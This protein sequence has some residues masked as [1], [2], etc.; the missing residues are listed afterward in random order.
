MADLSQ[1][2]TE[3]L[4]AMLASQTAPPAAPPAGNQPPQS[5]VATT[6]PAPNP[7]VVP[8]ITAPTMDL[9]KIPTD[10]L[11]RMLDKQ[12]SAAPTTLPSKLA[13][14]TTSMVK[15]ALEGI[16]QTVAAPVNLASSAIQEGLQLAAKAGLVPD[17]MAQGFKSG[18]A[19]VRQ[20]M[21][22]AGNAVENFIVPSDTVGSAAQQE[23]PQISKY[24]N[25]V[26]NMVGSA[27]TAGGMVGKLL[28][29]ASPVLSGAATQGAQG[30]LMGA[31]ANPE[32]PWKG[33]TIGAGIGGAGGAISGYA[34]RASQIINDKIDDAERIG[35]PAM[36]EAGLK[37]IKGAFDSGGKDLTTEESSQSTNIA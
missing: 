22:T 4:Q 16:G 29:A 36:S 14:G 26:G 6:S 19:N 15:G 10:Q 11:Q 33:A 34:T 31:S 5:P 30:L 37:S 7:T 2:P 35:V 17:S 1:I 27:A 3:Q 13:A 28:P 21:K 12:I 9:S 20:G 18:A 23:N 32:S 25:V 24:G 8:P